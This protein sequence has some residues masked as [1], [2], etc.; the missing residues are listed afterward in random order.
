MP[1]IAKF[2]PRCHS[3][4]RKLPTNSRLHTER[5]FY[6]QRACEGAIA[7]PAKV[8]PLLI[9]RPTSR[10]LP[11]NRIQ[12]LQANVDTHSSVSLFRRFE[13]PTLQYRALVPLE[14]C[15]SHLPRKLTAVWPK[16]CAV[17]ISNY[18]PTLQFHPC[19]PTGVKPVQGRD[20]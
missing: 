20:V 16:A 15:A 11:R 1:I 14:F 3:F 19:H 5:V 2:I 6:P 8:L 12:Y 17:L 9:R 7:K 4:D 10:N 18:P 13:P